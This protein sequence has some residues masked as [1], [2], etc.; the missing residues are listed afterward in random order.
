[1][2]DENR[3]TSGSDNGRKKG[4][5]LLDFGRTFLKEPA[6]LGSVLPSSRYLVRRALDQIDW[7]R[8]E[9]IVEYGPG[10]GTFTTEI[11]R[12]MVP[13]GRLVV[14]ETHP[15]FVR[16]LKE[17]LPDPRLEVIHGSAEA[18]E[19]TIRERGWKLVDYVL[20]GVPFSLMSDEVRDSILRS[21]RSVLDPDGAFLVY[22]FSPSIRSHLKGVFSD[23]TWEFELR[24]FLPATVFYCHP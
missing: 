11:L 22:Q 2:T 19:S 9:L 6:M 15:D 5:Q 8:A 14:F 24:N 3:E 12:R 4:R 10:L 7:A 1:M 16:H 20:S 18:V 23:V 13:G 21:T 17:S